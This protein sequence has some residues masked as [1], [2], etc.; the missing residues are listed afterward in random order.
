MQTNTQTASVSKPRLWAGR[1]LSALVV[2]FLVFDGVGKFVKPVQ[3]VEAFA[4]LGLSMNLS[5]AIGAI[6]L[7]CTVLYAIPHTST[8]GAILLTGFFGGA[9]AIQMRAGSPIFE[10]IFPIIFGVLAWAGI[11]LRDNRL[12]TLI[13]LRG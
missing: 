11:F 4:R 5:V 7:A 9:V 10:T 1:I 6:L 12:R 2:L 8:I 13:S 3:V